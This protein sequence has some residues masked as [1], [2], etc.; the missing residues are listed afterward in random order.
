[1]KF[2]INTP[3]IGQ[4]SAIEYN[5]VVV[6]TLERETG[7]V[8]SLDKW[9]FIIEERVNGELIWH[10]DISPIAGC[11]N[12]CAAEK[13]ITLRDHPEIRSTGELRDKNL[14]D[15]EN[16]KALKPF[17]HWNGGIRV[18]LTDFIQKKSKKNEI[19][20][21]QSEAVEYLV[22]FSGSRQDTDA[23]IA[24]HAVLELNRYY[25]EKHPEVYTDVDFGSL[26]DNTVIGAVLNRFGVK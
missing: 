14:S 15:E 19:V 22:A 3:T 7:Y 12:E 18:H 13:I 11:G 25:R 17:V 5:N 1:M 10:F 2:Q 16:L 8:P 26:K 24:T 4:E 20:Y 9:R 23:I 6:R 21:L